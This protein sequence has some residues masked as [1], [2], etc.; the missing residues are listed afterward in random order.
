M[1]LSTALSCAA[2]GAGS[3]NIAEAGGFWR[4]PLAPPTRPDV[5]F[6]FVPAMLDHGCHRLPGRRHPASPRF[7]ARSRGRLTL[8]GT[9]PATS[10]GSRR[11]TCR[12]PRASDL[13]MMVECAVP[14]EIFA[15]PAFGIPIAGADLPGTQRPVRCRAGRLIR[16]KAESVYHPVE[17]CRWATTT[18][19]WMRVMCA[20][21]KARRVVDAS[22]MPSLPGGNTTPD[23]HD[24]RAR[25]RPDQGG[26]SSRHGDTNARPT[27]I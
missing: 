27:A 7:C 3:S 13:R 5:Q 22:V 25:R 11:T 4:S 21:S 19:R 6:H 9:A 12:M 10:C 16:R 20:A 23:D 17:T 18:R 24:R 2:T 14:R 26:L 15:Q 8:A 1:A